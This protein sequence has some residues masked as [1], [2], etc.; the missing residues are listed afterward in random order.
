MYSSQI[1]WEK[2]GSNSP[3]II[4]LAPLAD[5]DTPLWETFLKRE[6]QEH[7]KKLITSILADRLPRRF[8]D[9]LVDEYFPLIRETYA[10]SI[11]RLDRE[12]IAELL[13]D[14]IPLTLIERR[15]GD[16]FVTA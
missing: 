4:H 10:A 7:P 5:M 16:E 1:A 14:G 15:P 8:V 6:F 12:R 13:G 3:K 2:L 9:G 11:S